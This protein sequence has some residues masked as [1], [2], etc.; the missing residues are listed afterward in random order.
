MEPSSHKCPRCGDFPGF[1]KTHN[2]FITA[3]DGGSISCCKCGCLHHVCATGIRVGSPGPAMC[4]HCSGIDRQSFAP[5]KPPE[6]F[7]P[8]MEPTQIVTPRI[9]TPAKNVE[10]P[11]GHVDMRMPYSVRSTFPGYK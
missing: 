4:V 10:R 6:H 7:M 1:G 8:H 9:Q 5:A 2:A 3:N 11:S